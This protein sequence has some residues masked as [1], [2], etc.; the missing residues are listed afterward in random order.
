MLAEASQGTLCAV[1]PKGSWNKCCV[2]R[3]LANFPILGNILVAH[4]VYIHFVV[5]LHICRKMA[6]LVFK[7]F[8]L[9]KSQNAFDSKHQALGIAGYFRIVAKSV[10]SRYQ[11][12]ASYLTDTTT[13]RMWRVRIL[14]VVSRCK[15]AAAAKAHLAEIVAII[16]EDASNGNS[17]YRLSSLFEEG[18]GSRQVTNQGTRQGFIL[19]VSADLR[20]TIENEYR[21]AD[22]NIGENRQELMAQQIHIETG[23][24]WEESRASYRVRFKYYCSDIVAKER[25]VHIARY[26]RNDLEIANAVA[27]AAYAY[28]DANSHRITD[29]NEERYKKDLKRAALTAA[30]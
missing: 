10:R 6:A 11:N 12:A 8:L 5:N 20:S 23:V 13:D 14:N 17:A 22:G 21:M 15:D 19:P 3:N 9:P 26:E 4:A 24:S 27:L 2:D 16:K 25:S 7:N 29:E 28:H 30:V 18:V 1:P